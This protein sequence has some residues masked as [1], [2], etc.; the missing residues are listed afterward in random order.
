M[1]V[2]RRVFAALLVAG[3]IAGARGGAQTA[4]APPSATP[5]PP[6]ASRIDSLTRDVSSQLRC[7]VCQGE[8]IQDSPSSLA[9]EMRAVVRSRLEAGKSPDE[10]KAYFVS[11]Y[12]DWILLQ[13]PAKGFT[14]LVYV[15]P[16]VALLVGAGI[17]ML[18][19]RRWTAGPVRDVPES[20]IDSTANAGG[21]PTD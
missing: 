14:G 5:A 4:S 13:P 20:T 15:L 9:Q 16:V 7:P 19:V 11:K 17:V 6:S 2:V 12:G 1:S 21:S 8:S 3:V 18:A 10:V